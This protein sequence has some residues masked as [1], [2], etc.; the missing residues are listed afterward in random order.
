MSY[1]TILRCDVCGKEIQDTDGYNLT[2]SRKEFLST[3]G[4][5]KNIETIDACS[6]ECL[7]DAVQKLVQAKNEKEAIEIAEEMKVK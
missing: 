6:L 7:S 2:I 1:I 5:Y 4:L 3:A